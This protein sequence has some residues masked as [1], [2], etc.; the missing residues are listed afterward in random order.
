M[1]PYDI[2]PESIEDSK[3]ILSS[4]DLLKITLA[5]EFIRA[6]NSMDSSKILKIT[7][8]H[9]SDLSRIR[10]MNL[11]RFT[12]DKLVS[13]LDSIGLKTMVHVEKKAS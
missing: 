6:T 12:L 8:L 10:S 3:E 4:K 9:K 13:I 2:D 11:E 1:N 5:S 7:G